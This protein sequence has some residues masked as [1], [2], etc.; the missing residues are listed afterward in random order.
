M[1]KQTFAINLQI[2]TNIFIITPVIQSKWKNQVFI[3]KDFTLRDYA[4]RIQ[5]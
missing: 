2:A 3:A 4:L 5:L 1:C